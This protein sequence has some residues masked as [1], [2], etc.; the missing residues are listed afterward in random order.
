[1]SRPDMA[2]TRLNVEQYDA[3]T[4]GEHEMKVSR[5]SVSSSAIILAAAILAMLPARGATA[6]VL[7]IAP[8]TPTVLQPGGSE[9]ISVMFTASQTF[10]LGE[11]DIEIAFD[12]SRFSVSNVLAG[13]LDPGSG[14]FFS[15]FL[16]NTGGTLNTGIFTNG[17]NAAATVIPIGTTGTL[18]TF[19]LTALANAPPGG[20]LGDINLLANANNSNQTPTAVYDIS[21]N[22]ISL[23]PTPTNGYDPTIDTTVIVGAA[24]PEPSSLVLMGLGGL[25]VAASRFRKKARRTPAA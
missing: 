21:A 5:S 4:S 10:T 19:T 23:S 18:E 2:K 17:N 13:N 3:R 22:S 14:Y 8:S 6:S 9:T 16:D 7:Y 1:M 12:A 24:V 25:M 11:A 20:A 15:P